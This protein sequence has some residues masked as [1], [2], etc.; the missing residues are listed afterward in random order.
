MY[1][2]AAFAF[3]VS[4]AS[5]V[6][7]GRLVFRNSVGDRRAGSS[8]QSPDQSPVLV[9]HRQLLV[10]LDPPPGRQYLL[11]QVLL[12]NEITRILSAIEQGDSS[13]AEQL[14]PLV[15]NELRKLAAEKMAHERPGQTLEATAL[16]HEAYLRLVDGKRCP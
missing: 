1:C 9:T 11:M 6:I 16:V 8:K 14:L 3:F 13:T 7:N 4:P 5:Q 2:L 12:M 10:H 15:Y